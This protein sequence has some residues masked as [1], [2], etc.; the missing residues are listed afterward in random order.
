M[1]A[2]SICAICRPQSVTTHD[3]AACCRNETISKSPCSYITG[4]CNLY[5]NAF[6]IAAAA[7]TTKEPNKIP[8]PC[9]LKM[10][11]FLIQWHTGNCVE[12]GTNSATCE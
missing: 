9:I 1:C 12:K 4:H 6:C 10:I 8:T 3:T 7:T 2:Q 5:A 11:L